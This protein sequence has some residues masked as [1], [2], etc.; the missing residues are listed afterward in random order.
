MLGN[1]HT[2][3]HIS[4]VCS[5]LCFDDTGEMDK[6]MTPKRDPRLGWPL[7]RL[8]T[9]VHCRRGPSAKCWAFKRITRMQ[10][11]DA[12]WFFLD[13]P[14]VKSYFTGNDPRRVAL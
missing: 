14:L 12:S 6:D 10:V 5:W 2:F 7:E 11:I 13:L 8:S 4:W 3:A 9:D 1:S